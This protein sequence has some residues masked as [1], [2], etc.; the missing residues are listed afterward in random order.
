[1]V[2]EAANIAGVDV[3]IQV[4]E[5]Y[6][7]DEIENELEEVDAI[8]IDDLD[9]KYL[10]I[11]HTG[12]IFSVTGY[13]SPEDGTFFSDEAYEG[14]FDGETYAIPCFSEVMVLY[15]RNGMTEFEGGTWNDFFDGCVESGE[16]NGNYCVLWPSSN[17]AEVFIFGNAGIDFWKELME[18]DLLQQFSVDENDVLSC[19]ISGQTDTVFVIDGLKFFKQIQERG[20]ESERKIVALPISEESPTQV[21][22]NEFQKYR[23]VA[24]SSFYIFE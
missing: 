9:F 8:L 3:D 6:I 1:M 21:K 17:L 2:A 13:F 19:I 10:M 11:H 4:M 23:T 18:A 5:E 15:I 7:I 22:L 12:I 20:L 16:N 14:I 24:L